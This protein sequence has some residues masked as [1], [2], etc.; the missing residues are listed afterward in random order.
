MPAAAIKINGTL[1]S[2][3]SYDI[4]T[5]ATL[6]NQSTGGETTFLWELLDQ[7]E[8]TA[9]TLTG[10]GTATCTFTPTK[11]GSYLIRLTVNGTL[12]NLVVLGVRQ[13]KSGLRIP[14]A[15]ETSEASTTLGWARNANQNLQELDR[16][17]TDGGLQVWLRASGVTPYVVGDVVH[18]TDVGTIK[19]GLPGEEVVVV[20]EDQDTPAPVGVTYGVVEELLPTS[21]GIPTQLVR[22]RVQGLATIPTIAGTPAIGAQVYAKETGTSVTTDQTATTG[23]WLG[24][25]IA[26]SAGDWKVLF[27]GIP[28]LRSELAGNIGD[29]QLLYRTGSSGIRALVLGSAGTV[30]KSSGTSLSYGTLTYSDVGADPAGA[31]AAAEAAANGYTDTAIA[32]RVP[33]T[34]TLQGTSPI[35][36]DGVYTAVNLSANRTF[37][38]AVAGQAA[39]DIL[40]FNG[41]SWTRFG[42]GGIGQVLTAGSGVL[43]WTTPSSGP[44]A[45]IPYICGKNGTAP[46]GGN[47]PY[48]TI[49]DMISAMVADGAAWETP[50]VGFLL[51][52]VNTDYYEENFTL[53][54]GV[55]LVGYGNDPSNTRIAG[56]ITV[57]PAYDGDTDRCGLM[58]LTVEP[59]WAASPPTHALYIT[60]NGDLRVLLHDVRLIASEVAG[61]AIRSDRTGDVAVLATGQRCEAAHTSNSASAAVFRLDSGT[62]I[63]W[64]GQVIAYTA[65]TSGKAGVLSSASE[66]RLTGNGYCRGQW[67]LDAAFVRIDEKPTMEAPYESLFDLSNGAEVYGEGCPHFLVDGPAIDI[68]TAGTG[69]GTWALKSHTCEPSA[70]QQY[71]ISN[72]ITTQGVS[73]RED[74][75]EQVVTSLPETI[76]ATANLCVVT[77]GAA[78]TTTLPAAT[79]RTNGQLLWLVNQSAYSQDF[80][81]AGS[82]TINGAS[83]PLTLAPNEAALVCVRHGTTNWQVLARGAGGAGTYTLPFFLVGPAG[84]GPG[85]TSPAYASITAAISAAPTNATIV[86]MDGTYS[87]NVTIAKN[88]R[89]VSWSRYVGLEASAVGVVIDGTVTF[90]PDAAGRKQALNG[91][92]VLQTTSGYA[93][94]ITGSNDTDVDLSGSEAVAS[95][96]VSTD[97]A[98][99]CD[100]TSAAT[101]V[102]GD[103][104]RVEAID[105]NGDA[106]RAEGAAHQHALNG[107]TIKCGS[108]GAMALRAKDSALIGLHHAPLI[109]GKVL[110]DGGAVVMRHCTHDA[111][112]LA[113]YRA[114]S[115]GTVTAEFC[116]VSS[117]STGDLVEYTGAGVGGFVY[118][119]LAISGTVKRTYADGVV[120]VPLSTLQGMG[121]QTLTASGNVDEN[122]DVLMLN[123]ASVKVE[124]TLPDPTRR[125]NRPLY[126][127][128][129]SAVAHDLKAYAGTT[130]EGASSASIAAG[131]GGIIWPRVGTTDWKVI[132]Y[133]DASGGGSGTVPISHVPLAGKWLT[134]A[135]STLG[136]SA[137]GDA[138]QPAE[139]DYSGART[140]KFRAML[141]A[142]VTSNNVRVRLWSITD[143]AYVTDLDGSG[144]NYLQTNSLTGAVLVSPDLRTGHTNFTVGTADRIYEV[145]IESTDVN[146]Q[147]LLYWAELVVGL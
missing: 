75:Y 147:A 72:S 96:G 105:G 139:H 24:T 78:G 81:R 101:R 25:I 131:D 50:K 114:G 64:P 67:A 74:L 138:W 79:K 132:A 26:G 135:S 143:G 46:N 51:P 1:G 45:L 38:L 70:T 94:R 106:Y 98:V 113:P 108:A 84:S 58:N 69:G 59:G 14:A 12:Q 13:L 119:L 125:L 47:A 57:N 27:Y 104:L 66:V 8:G 68:A 110:A 49:T 52:G 127:K 63:E 142:Q 21:P 42:L 62:L 90:S 88:H 93:I 121:E 112:N 97:H 133:Y 76:L 124:A 29:Y 95:S 123:H 32:T 56:Q 16:R 71:T 107:A 144:N 91:I 31:A 77:A 7:P 102:N 61:S 39:G 99:F 115:S 83:T 126:F 120:P 22:V 60:G 37:S 4:G 34:R 11:E 116:R 128:N 89:V 129:V 111:T 43:S 109:Q 82:D 6:T 85:G 100:N 55:F 36:I 137:G 146:T 2:N 5:L 18:A 117:T 20:S 15:G 41:T 130:I 17:A 48:S 10:A 118:G 87:G 3:L 40:Y 9:N 134:T 44:T 35:A 33:T 23:S 140:V 28:T 141:A 80:A 92:R 122:T 103:G 73:K 65:V 54:D 86:A 145:H 53:P 136:E 30:L 19:V